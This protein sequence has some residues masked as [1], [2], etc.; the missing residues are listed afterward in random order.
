MKHDIDV[1]E[2]YGDYFEAVS[3]ALHSIFME[4]VKDMNPNDEGYDELSG[5][6]LSTLAAAGAES[7]G[8]MVGSSFVGSMAPAFRN[9]CQAVN[10]G[11]E[12]GVSEEEESASLH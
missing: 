2:L 7:I 9:L 10:A 3:E 8:Y 6:H 11:I 1:Q 12:N 4:A 5:L